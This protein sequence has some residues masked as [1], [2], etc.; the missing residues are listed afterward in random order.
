MQVH[1][2]TIMLDFIEH[3]A[4]RPDPAILPGPASDVQPLLK[5]LRAYRVNTRLPLTGGVPAACG[6]SLQV[7]IHEYLDS[8]DAASLLNERL[9]RAFDKCLPVT[10]AMT[11][12]DGDDGVEKS[13]EAFCIGIRSIM[14]DSQVAGCLLGTC[15]RSHVLPLQAYLVI[16]SILGKGPRYVMLDCLQ[17]QHHSDAR[18]QAATDANWLDLWHRRGTGRSAQ[19]VYSES[20][21]SG[22][23][24]MADEKTASILPGMA[25]PVPVASAWFP[26]EIFLPDF[27]DGSGH[28]HIPDLR[29]ALHACLETNERLAPF[30]HSACS[31]LESDAAMNNRIALLISGIGDLVVERRLD[32][33][34][35]RCLRWVE[36]IVSAIRNELRDHSM[37]LARESETLPS[38]LQ[39]DP[40]N[41]WRNIDHRE[42]WS[43][44][45][46]Q[47]LQAEAVRNRN[48]LVLSPYSVLPRGENAS[49]NY[50]DLLP[51]LAHA[52][53]ISFRAPPALRAWNLR[54]F[55]NFHKRAWLVIMRESRRTRIAAGA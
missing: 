5:A 44:R 42:D 30:L 10:I 49:P 47:M 37:R 24:L 45:W 32:P 17:M 2:R 43:G 9:R 11:V 13:L 55:S 15:I 46:Q 38:L 28:L 50:I 19:P 53:A 39:S 20:V 21:R 41:A 7:A 12:T 36:K 52:D 40:S 33:T 29:A 48:L 1:G 26:V 14:Q 4:H 25:M 34:E 54:E 8:G 18:V 31:A 51:V 3:K 23:P 27:S 35:I 6:L 16:T 22:C